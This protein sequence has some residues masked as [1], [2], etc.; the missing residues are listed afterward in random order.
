[1]NRTFRIIL[2]TYCLSFSTLLQAKSYSFG[3]VPQQSASK[4]ASL[5]V[6][7]LSN[8]SKET[9]H[10]IIFKTAKNIP[11][12]ERNLAAGV[13][14][15]AYMNPYHYTV[16]HESSKYNAIAKA[17][18]KR[19][20][21]IIVIKKGSSFKHLEDLKNST[22]A[23]PSPGAFAASMLTQSE[24]KN[25]GIP[26]TPKYV[27]SHDSVYRNVAQGRLNAGGGVM[28]TLK[29]MEQDI[30]DQLKIL[31]ISDGYT[32]HAIAAHERVPDKHKLLV[33]EA[34]ASFASS[35]SNT[36]LL[37]RIK[38][39]GFEKASNENWNDVRGLQIG[40]SK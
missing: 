37:S 22:I 29:N 14:D 17:K 18:D 30:R 2:I 21:G 11:E 6:P 40:V 1:M 32:P 23:F 33:Q 10:K 26:I 35:N 3:I 24:F 19:I 38:L 20:K 31:W 39:K 36:R 12:F 16:F 34:L 25:R 8:I 7:I 5:W 27:S 9:G 15:F 28:R 4:L 13:Y